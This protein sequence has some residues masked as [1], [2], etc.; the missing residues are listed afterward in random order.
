MNQTT[1]WGVALG[2]LAAWYEG[3]R[4]WETIKTEQGYEYWRRYYDAE[5]LARGDTLR[6][7]DAIRSTGATLHIDVYERPERDAPVVIF[8]HGGAGY[9]RLFVPLALMFYDRGYT[10]VLPDQRGQGFSGGARGDYTFGECVQ[11]IVDV[12]RW[13]KARWNT[14]LFLAGGSVGGALSYYAAAAGA[15]AQAIACVNLYDFG[16][17]DALEFS[18]LAPLAQSATGVCWLRTALK[19]LTPFNRL[20]VPSNWLARFDKLMDARDA[21][22]Q[23][24]WDDDPIPPRLLSLRAIASNLN[25]PPTVPFEHNR[26]PTLVINQALDQMTDPAITQRNYERLGGPKRYQEIP[27]GHWS[28]EP[29]FW[30]ASVAA[31]DDWFTSYLSPV[32]T[33]DLA[34]SVDAGG[35]N[36]SSMPRGKYSSFPRSTGAL[37]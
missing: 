34:V 7:V 36:F 14:P 12:A 29:E 20:R 33:D 13:A 19:W 25:T 21:K 22:F 18:R 24:Q 26:V 35:R 2:A 6:Q 9:C 3:T 10:M 23:Q 31:A 1:K 30:Q 4:W 37:S 8:N 5:T 11:N 17:G 32:A 28:R 15:P 16:G 27:F